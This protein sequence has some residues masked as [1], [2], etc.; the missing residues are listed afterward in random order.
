MSTESKYL[1]NISV[2][3][4]LF[5]FTGE[6]LNVLL[7]ERTLQSANGY[8]SFSDLTLTGHHIYQDEDLDSAA[9]RIVKDLTGLNGLVLEQFYT[10]GALDRLIHAN[11]QAW[12]KQ[13]GDTISNR[14]ISVG[15]Y[16]LI[17][18]NTQIM[19]KGRKV[20]WCP[21]SSIENLAY[22]HKQILDKAVEHLQYKLRTEHIG[23]E[24]LPEKFTLSQMQKL[25]EAILA[26]E[27]D[28]RNFRKK[29]SQMSY[30]VP[31]NERQTGVSHKPAQLFMFSR[32]I[33]EK[34]KKELIGF[35]I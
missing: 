34:T 20:K 2:D 19:S 33:Y 18:V 26:V 21:V 25:Y 13:F 1:S 11:D 9:V 4:V 8:E 32:D 30:V 5:G 24:L 31:L 10:F 22:D 16:S 17:P 14:V 23:F 35:F 28:K 27:F 29:V 15:Y 7:V 6:T 12:L 3:C